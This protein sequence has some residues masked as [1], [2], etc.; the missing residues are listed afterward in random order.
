MAHT[1]HPTSDH[2]TSTIRPI[3]ICGMGMRL[4]GNIRDSESFWDTLVNGKDARGPVPADRYNVDGFSDALGKKGAIET[5][6]GYFIDDDLTTL[7]TSFFSMSKAELERIDPQQRQ[8]LEVTREALENAGEVGYRGKLIGCY[9]GNFAEDWLQ[10]S[11]KETQHS[12]GYIMTGHGDLMLANRVSYEFDLKGPSHVISMVIKTGCSASLVGL[13]EACRALL[14]GDCVGAIVAGANLIMG[15]TTTAAMTQEGILSP[16]GSCKTF[17]A[18]AD[19]FAR[20]DAITAVYI[21]LLDDAIRDNNPIRAVIRNTGTNSDGKSQGLMTPNPESHEALMRK[22]YLDAG[23]DP[24]DTAFVECHGTGTPTGDPLETSAVGKVFG[25]K[26]VYI[27]SVKPNIGHSEGASGVTSLIKAVLALEH[28]TIP[29]NIKFHK[30]NLKIPFTE[31]NLVVPVKATAWPSDRAKRISINS[32]GIGGSNAHVVVDAPSALYYLNRFHQRTKIGDKLAIFSANSQDSA[33]WYMDS[34]SE[35]IAQNIDLT[36]DLAY[37]LALHREHLPHRAFAIMSDIGSIT[38]YS[39]IS[40]VPNTKLK[41]V[42]VFSGQGAQWPEMGK[43]L[44]DQDNDFREDIE[45][46]DRILQSLRHPPTWAIADELRAPASTSQIHRAE[47]SQ[48][49]STAIQ[50]AIV[51]GFRRRGIVPAAV[52]GHSSGEIAAAFAS[53]VISLPEAMIA[54]YYRG[55]VTKNQKRVGAMAAIGLGVKEA[56]LFLKDGIVIACDNSP[57]SVTFSGD[58]ELIDGTIKAIKEAK[59][60]VLARKLKVDMAYHSDHM[61]SLGSQ[62]LVLL[63]HELQGQGLIRHN[64]KVPMFSSVTESVITQGTELR[65]DYWV[66]NLTSRPASLFL[67]IGPHSTLSGPLRQISTASGSEYRYVPTMLRGKSCVNSFLSALGQMH[68]NGI[69]I[70]WTAMV[71]PGRVLTNLPR[72]AY[73]H[74]GSFWYEARLSKQWRF[75]QFGYHR[76]LGLRIPESSSLEPSWRNLVSLEDEPWLIDH[77]LR[78]DVVFPFAAYVAMVGEAVRQITGVE[79]GYRLRHVTARSALVLPET[80]AVE[81]LTTLRRVKVSDSVDSSWFEFR[82][83]SYSNST[84]ITNCEGQVGACPDPVA[85]SRQVKEEILPRKISATRWYEDIENLGIVYGPEFQGLKDIV[86]STTEN[87]A[88]AKI[89]RNAHRDDAAFLFHPAAIDACLQLL[90]VALAKGIGRNFGGLRVPTLIE[91]LFVSRSAPQMDAT[92]WA[93]GT[94]D[95][96]IE[97]VNGGEIALRLSGLTLTA[98]DDGHSQTSE[99]HAAARLEWLPDFDMVDHATLFKPPRSTPI[100]IRMHEELTLL[101]M[102]ESVERLRG[103]EPCQEHFAKLR[104]WMELETNRARDGVYPVLQN[105]KDFAETPS[106]VRKE[107]IESRYQKVLKFSAKSAEGIAIKRIYDNCEDLFTGRVDTLDTLMEDGILTELYNKINFI[108]GDFFRLL[109]HT[110]PNLRILEVGAGTGGTTETILRDLVRPDRHPVYGMYTFTDVS[111]GFFPQAKERFAYAPNMDYRV[112]D[113]STSPFKQGFEPASYDVIL[114]PNVVH[115]TASLHSTLRNLQLLLRPNEILVLTEICTVLRTSN[116]I[117]GNFSEWWLGEADGRPFEPHVPVARWDDELKTA[118]FSGVNTLVLDAAEPYNSCAVIVSRKV[119]DVSTSLIKDRPVTVLCNNPQGELTQHFLKDIQASGIS[120]SVCR[121]GELLPV[122]HDIVSLLDLETP[123]FESITKDRLSAFQD[124]LKNNNKRQILWLTKPSQVKCKNPHSAQAIGVAR[125]IRSELAIPFY[126]LEIEVEEAKFSCLVQKV[127]KKIQGCEDTESLAPDREYIVDNG[128][129]KI[130]RYQTFSVKEERDMKSSAIGYQSMKSLSISR[131]GSLES[132]G[133]VHEPK[134]QKIGD[135]E[136]EIEIR[137][138]GINFKDVLYAKDIL[139]GKA[140]DV[141]LGLEVSGEVRSVGANVRD[142]SLGDRVLAMPPKPCFKTHVTVPAVLVER[143]PDSLGFEDAATMPICYTTVLESLINI[144]QLEKGQSVLIHSAAG[145]V[146]HAAIHVCQMIGIEIFATVGNHAKVEYLVKTFGISRTHI[147]NSR[148]DSFAVDIMRETDGRG[149]DIVLNSVSGELLHASWNCVAEFGKMV[150]LGKRDI[151]DFGKLQMNNFMQSRSYCCVDMTHLA[152]KRPKK[153]GAILKKVIELYQDGSIPPLHPISTYDARAVQDAFR[154]V[155]DG[156]HIGKV[157]VRMPRNT[158]IIPSLPRPTQLQFKSDAS[159]LLTGGLGGLGKVISTWLV[160]RGVRSLVY[161]SRSAGKRPEDQEFFHELES[162]GCSVTAVAGKAESMEDV[163]KAISQ[164][165]R[166]IAGVLH[167]AM[168]LRDSPI[169]SMTHSA[170]VAANEPKV[171]GAWNLHE[172]LK[173]QLLDFFVLASSL[174]TIVEQP[175]QGNYSAS[176][177]FLE[178]FCQYR[179]SLSLPASVLNICPIDGVGFLAQNPFAKRNMKTQGYYFLR[180]PELL[181]FLELSIFNSSPARDNKSNRLESWT[182][183][184]QIAMGLHSVGDINDPNT[185]TNWRR[186]R[187]MGF[188]HNI[189]EKIPNNRGGSSE[190]ADFILKVRDD[191]EL[192]SEAAS[193]VYLAR[194]IGTKVFSLL[195]KPEENVD[196]SLTLAQIGLDSLM[197]IKLRRWWKQAF[198]LEKSVLEIMAAGTLESLGRGLAQ[199]LK[200]KLTKEP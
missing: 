163:G 140:G 110:R 195:L 174:V 69:S 23:L 179:H 46:M 122:S 18:T 34:I 100:D 25:K 52:V 71:T 13:H 26:G 180:E 78:S 73:D 41:V 167:L 31:K 59:P 29:P 124:V 120:A 6:F 141:P 147:F 9:V 135:E 196:I 77:K 139:K 108:N 189:N 91:D 102:L 22:V 154:Q 170:W 193:E 60:D 194:E 138:I 133:W 153:A 172:S 111:A 86:S 92:A 95:L 84:W 64:P 87:M 99:L 134:S 76:V 48:P 109:T 61:V 128:V 74:S 98:V 14:S 4:P 55:F 47:L 51:Q 188:Y 160:E 168:V 70:D 117:F 121:L 3:A 113:I 93:N 89:V 101:C 85:P 165:P 35:Y 157:V 146:G 66:A 169:I 65:P 82:I 183:S 90:L 156:N 49:L 126:T 8:L 103:L 190:L 155:Q 24:T 50:I 39:P 178:A 112:F 151:V 83:C 58:V 106:R 10:L 130:G 67:E 17:D 57:N 158:S 161:L 159:Y 32:F 44:L 192:L 132:L 118:G 149:V 143:I 107:M 129:I 177:T 97:C 115:A 75:R 12:G 171:R 88:A 20:G 62:L 36:S 176:N 152:Q 19:G 7:D 28:E 123:F 131:P 136:V 148:N 162:S 199:S 11:A 16:E 185:R 166:R 116:Y 181:D 142:I 27:G 94:G 53:G 191:P 150:E 175:G 144:G 38:E 2:A 182:N 30:P 198:G 80:E 173:N 68:Q 42:M 125:S 145:G 33:R 105:S 79:E 5:K 164:A 200:V 43:D 114:A 184:S 187:R 1:Q 96:L 45:E 37:T 186:D 104:D 15:P 197:F 119:E 127:L 40:K 137:A 81:M 21:K 56:S 72:Y 54:S 63:E